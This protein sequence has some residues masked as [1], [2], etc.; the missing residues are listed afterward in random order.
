MTNSNFPDNAPQVLHMIQRFIRLRK[1]FRINGQN[2]MQDLA[3]HF[4]ESKL[5]GIKGELPEPDLFYS[6][7]MVLSQHKET[8]S[9]GELSHELDVP[10]S[11][12]TRIMDWLTKN[13]YTERYTDPQDRRV[14]RV[15]LTE[16]GVQT[17][18]ALN[19]TILESMQKILRLY[20][21]EEI[22]IMHHLL[23]KAFDAIE[24]EEL[25]SSRDNSQ[26]SR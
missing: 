12:A 5:K 17:Y 22:E 20:T 3:K 25:K 21:L 7:G 10:L 9:M 13:G 16:D 6:V 8:I 11:S 4:H 14:V 15:G 26:S 2:R 19:A 24:N 23:V 18:A 1:Y